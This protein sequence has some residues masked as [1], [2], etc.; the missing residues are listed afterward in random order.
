MHNR[1]SF[2]EREGP[3]FQLPDLAKNVMVV[4]AAPAGN[5]AVIFY[6]NPT[7]PHGTNVEVF[8]A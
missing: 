6:R 4:V 1:L 8:L 5:W 7:E 2:V 3:T